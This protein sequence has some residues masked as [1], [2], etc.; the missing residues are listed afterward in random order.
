MSSPLGCAH[1]KQ[2]LY[3][4]MPLAPMVLLLDTQYN[5]RNLIRYARLH[6]SSTGKIYATLGWDHDFNLVSLET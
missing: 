5:V 6:Y 1:G 4:N 3:S 2:T